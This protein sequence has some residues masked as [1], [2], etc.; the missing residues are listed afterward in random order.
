MEITLLEAITKYGLNTLIIAVAINILTALIKV[1]IKALANKSKEGKGIT[2]YITFLP[3]IIGFGLT[4]LYS[5]I[6]FKKLIL[7]GNFVTLWLSSSS[8]SLAI[9]AFKEKFFP[10][11]K[12]ILEKFEIEQNIDLIDK[13]KKTF[14]DDKKEE[15]LGK[16]KKSQKIILR[17]RNNNEKNIK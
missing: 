3:V 16:E 13:I 15:T 14:F 1:P 11:K 8:L 4:V 10:S 17:A 6:L 2:R 7:D 9:Y 5:F 12:K